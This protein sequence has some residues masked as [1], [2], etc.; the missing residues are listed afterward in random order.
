MLV[1]QVPHFIYHAAHLDILATPIDRVLQTASLGL[2][3]L[4]PLLVCLAAR[5]ISQ[6][7]SSKIGLSDGVQV[8]DAGP[9]PQLVTSSH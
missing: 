7:Q 2:T 9:R 1:A 4:I 6:R 5:G 8:T 3:L